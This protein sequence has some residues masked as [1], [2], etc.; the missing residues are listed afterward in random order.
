MTLSVNA[1][2]KD[3]QPFI[4]KDTSA[5]L[6][7]QKYTDL[8]NE[9]IYR[10]DLSEYE[11]A[12]VVATVSQNYFV[13]VSKDGKTWI[14]IQDYAAVNGGR[15]EGGSNLATVGASAQKYAPDSDY[16]Y[17]RFANADVQTGWGTALS[18]IEIYYLK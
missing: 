1:S 15:I 6:P 5:T 8:S 17:L 14:T 13:Q 12:V 16:L 7:S 18:K 9:I 3:D 11:D 2:S 10:F 4:V